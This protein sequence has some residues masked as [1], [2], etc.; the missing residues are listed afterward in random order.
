MSGNCFEPSSPVTLGFSV[1]SQE[2]TMPANSTIRRAREH[3]E[4]GG[5]RAERSFPRFVDVHELR[6][7]LVQRVAHGRE[8]RVG[9]LQKV[10]PVFAERV[11]RH[12]GEG[13]AQLRL[14]LDEQGALFL[15]RPAGGLEFGFQAGAFGQQPCEPGPDEEPDD[16][17]AEQE[18]EQADNQRIGHGLNCTP[19]P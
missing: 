12:G 13:V 3:A 19:G 6:L 11:L 2:L 5:H 10:L 7:D 9:I 18:A 17:S 16:G 14:R 15:D 8:Q 4:L 1:K